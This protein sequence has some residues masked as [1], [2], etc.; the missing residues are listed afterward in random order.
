MPLF[1]AYDLAL[2]K[3]DSHTFGRASALLA[4]RDAI[5]FDVSPENN[6]SGKDM[7]SNVDA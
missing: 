2:E 1:T 5:N 3:F 4:R 7:R 6:T